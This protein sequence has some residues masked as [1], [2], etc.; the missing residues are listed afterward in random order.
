MPDIIISL[1][2]DGGFEISCYVLKLLTMTS[3]SD[4]NLQYSAQIGQF[5]TFT[6]SF[7]YSF[8]DVY[9]VDENGRHLI[10]E[11]VFPQK[12]FDKDFLDSDKEIHNPV[13]PQI[14]ST[15]QNMKGPSPVLHSRRNT[16]ISN[17]IDPTILIS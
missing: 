17:T 2:D 8:Y 14:V 9:T 12:D 10:S 3:V 16:S 5:N 6:A 15:K 13:R 7:V 1:L 4:L 11:P